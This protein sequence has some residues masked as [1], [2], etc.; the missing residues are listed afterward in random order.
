[1]AFPQKHQN[2]DAS[3]DI[4]T[5]TPLRYL[6]LDHVYSATSPCVSASGSSNVMS[7]KVKARKL[8]HFDDGD[9]NHQKPSPK[10]S[11]VNVYSRRAKR[12]R[13]YERSSSFFDALVAR[14]ESPAAAVKIEEADGDDEF[15]R[16]LEKKKRK[17]G[18]NELLKLG[19]D[20]SILCN[21]DGP[22][23][24]DSRSNHKLDRSKNG[25]KLRLKKR[26]SSVSC[27]KI[28]SDPSSVKKWVGLSFSDVDPKTFIGLQ[29]KVYW[30]LDANSYSGRIVGYN[31]DTNRHQVEYEDGDEEDL[32]LSN[33]RIKFYI[34]REEM[35]SL[36]LS[37][38]LKSMDNDVYDYNEMVVLAASLDDCQELEPG[39]IIWAKLTGYAMWPAIV[40]DESL[41]G[42]RKGLTK[43]LG[44][45]SVPV[46]FF[47]THDFARI[48][49]K[50]AI[51]FLK[52]LLS[53][54]HLKCKKPGFIKS[55]EEAKMY[56]NEQKL[57][58]RMLR[59]Q[60]GINI[61]ECESVSGEDEVS[62]DSG[63]GCLDDVGI[64]RTLDRLGTSPYVIGDLQITNLGKVVRDSEYF[65][66]EKDIWPEGY[67]ALRKFTS[68]TDPTVC[69]LYKMEVLRDTESKI[70][71]LFK[72]TLDTGEQFK[73]ST[74]SVCWNKIYKRIRK[75]QNTSLVGSNANA[76]GGLEGT[77]KS[78]S[79]M[80]GFSIPEVAK[81]IQGLIKS[82]LSSKL[83][84]C[85][86]ASRRYRDVPVGYRPVRVD[87]KDLDKCSVCHMDEEYENNLFLQC[88]KCRMMVHAR[89]Y[90][91][92]EPVGGV[93]WL[94]NLCRPGAPEPAPPCCLCPVIGGAMKPTTDG[95]WAHLA[96]AIWIPETC[97]SDVKRMEPIDGLSRINKDRW[98]LLCSICGVSYG[99][100]I[101]CS[102]NTCCAAYHP[103]CARAAGLCVELEDEDRLHLL[104]VEDD[105]ED[106]CIRLLSFCK[107][108]RQP[109]NDRSAADDR[110]GRTVRRCS[111]YTPPSNPSGCARTE[112]YN[113]FCRRGRKEPEAIAAASLKRLFVENQPYLVGG[114]SQHQLSS[115][116]RPP[117]GV[118]GSKFCSNLQRLKASQLDAPND[119][120]S[121]A[122]KYKYMRDTFRKRLAFG[123]SGIHGF[124]IFAKHPHRAGDMVI[125]YTGELVRPPVA[126]RREHFIYNSLVG[127]GTYMFRID[128]ERVIDATRAGSIAHLINHS[129]EP[130][131]YSRVI[132]VNNDEHIIIFAKRDI[133]RWEE[134]TYDYRFFSIDEQLACYCGFPRC[135]GVVNDVEAEERAT[136]HYA[137]R[138]EL[139]N[140]SG[141]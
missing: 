92:L 81:L 57:P 35:E 61:D 75:T 67:T 13:H 48:K 59:L 109:T 69:T 140:W 46:Q 113:Y 20:S 50:Q 52:G 33:E 18:I 54:F 25:E 14:N 90:G 41:I 94:C 26:N 39:D 104:S 89:C 86:L 100:C 91:E 120:L 32:I 96:C 80:F 107:K 76:D 134:L 68:I 133:K 37:Y 4:H 71:P 30:P 79:H 70:R 53:S 128:D 49:V 110:I 103:L 22:R 108:H 43:S 42:D 122:E 73:G 112:P 17:L 118:V 88:D 82:K 56:L 11:I 24:R 123:K 132:S 126:D 115:N 84:K 124:G 97:L 64:L 74:P 78:G 31:S 34:S 23:L 141:E 6:S 27:E 98:K 65:Q 136:K 137:P 93:L 125:E 7:K 101:Q 29:C 1:M 77:Y 9:Q 2:D 83:P 87:W 106:Q 21:L 66:D 111:D 51:S 62:A 105:E 16:G 3:I 116:S 95:R 99:A 45:R 139:I 5:S 8:N 12:P 44:G 135:R 119:I 117:N 36:N 47:G 130:N 127:A 102:N 28:L 55:L 121:M 114:Y 72:V 85:K 131:C 138:S 60:N 19:V 63:E 58:R 38:S 129:C 40:V 10:P 15:D